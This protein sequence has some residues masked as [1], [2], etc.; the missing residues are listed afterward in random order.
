[1]E[2]LMNKVEL[3]DNELEMANGGSETVVIDLSK[4]RNC[5]SIGPAPTRSRYVK[6][7]REIQ[8]D[9]RL[10]EMK[11]AELN[12]NELDMVNGGCKPDEKEKRQK[13]HSFKFT[14]VDPKERDLPWL[15]NRNK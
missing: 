9:E 14:P 10:A 5:K 2:A 1:M 4:H 6:S 13:K 11:R 3:M 12:N 8:L 7:L 15:A